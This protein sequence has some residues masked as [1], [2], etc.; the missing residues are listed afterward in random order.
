MERIK[1]K[2]YTIDPLYYDIV[3][4]TISAIVLII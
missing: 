2:I 4:K 1:G 3:Y